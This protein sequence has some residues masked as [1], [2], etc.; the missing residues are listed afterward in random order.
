MCN[1]LSMHGL[2]AVHTLHAPVPENVKRGSTRCNTARWS[3]A[4]VRTARQP[5]VAHRGRPPHPHQ[6]ALHQLRRDNILR[7]RSI[8]CSLCN[9]SHGM[10]TRLVVRTTSISRLANRLRSSRSSI[11]S[12]V[13]HPSYHPVPCRPSP[14]SSLGCRAILHSPTDSMRECR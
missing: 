13:A 11:L 8:R 5:T 12:T 2:S 6:I 10:L 7:S 14:S 1:F 3:R 9:H 4:T